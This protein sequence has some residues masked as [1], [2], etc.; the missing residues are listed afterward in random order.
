MEWPFSA[1]VDNRAYCL[2]FYL[3]LVSVLLKAF[4]L[5]AVAKLSIQRGRNGVADGAEQGPL[6]VLVGEADRRDG[7]PAKQPDDIR[8]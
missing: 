3:V 1:S 6:L 5:F 2:C 8:T 7:V 4:F